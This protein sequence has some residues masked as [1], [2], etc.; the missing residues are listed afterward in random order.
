M[1]CVCIQNGC[2]KDNGQAKLARILGFLLDKINH[3]REKQ[4][5]SHLE[6][7]SETRDNSVVIDNYNPD[8]ISSV[9]NLIPNYDWQCGC[10][11]R[12]RGLR[13]IPVWPRT[14][15]AFVAVLEESF[16]TI[17]NEF[18]AARSCGVCSLFQPYRAPRNEISGASAQTPSSSSAAYPTGSTIG[19]EATSAGAW[20]VCYLHLHGLDFED[21]KAVFPATTDII[22]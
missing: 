8:E 6:S 2:T 3:S 14:E 20:S 15:L 1:S 9:T 5:L 13:S 18:L 11:E 4:Y 10:P 19:S 17:R 22:R 21:N 16:E 12:V 7:G